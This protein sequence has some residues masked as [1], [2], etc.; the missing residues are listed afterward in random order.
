[1]SIHLKDDV[2]TVTTVASIGTPIGN[3]LLPPKGS[4]SVATISRLYFDLYFIN[5]HNAIPPSFKRAVPLSKAP[6]Q[7]LLFLNAI[8]PKPRESGKEVCR[9]KREEEESG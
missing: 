7:C 8:S 1:M 6:K 2:A 4:D 9:E 5:K 3:K